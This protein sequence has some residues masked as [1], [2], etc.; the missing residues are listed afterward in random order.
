MTFGNQLIAIDT[1]PTTF[2]E[3]SKHPLFGFAL[4]TIVSVLLWSGILYEAW[5]AVH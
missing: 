5:T 2:R 4:A 1:E 3:V